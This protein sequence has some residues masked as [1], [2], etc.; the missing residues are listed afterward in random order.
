MHNDNRYSDPCGLAKML[1]SLGTLPRAL[2]ITSRIR[3]LRHALLNIHES[4]ARNTPASTASDPFAPDGL[5]ADPA[6]EDMDEQRLLQTV[7]ETLDEFDEWDAG[8]ASYWHSTFEQRT[9]PAPVGSVAA[10]GLHYDLETACTIILLRSSRLILLEAILEYHRRKCQLDPESE[11]TKAFAEYVPVLVRNVQATIDD[12]IYCVPYALG[13]L[14]AN[15]Q[16]WRIEYDGAPALI[17][18]NSLRLVPLCPHS[19]PDQVAV[20]ESI[21]KR[22]NTN[23]GVR[24]AAPWPGVQTDVELSAPSPASFGSAYEVVEASVEPHGHEAA[25]GGTEDRFPGESSA[26]ARP[27]SYVSPSM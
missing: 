17:I 14:D 9:A 20:I 4:S 12:L 7:F 27:Y 1:E 3:G 26:L 16:P 22:I 6:L 19:T 18:L 8:A 11:T 2:F 5:S 21:L 23:M 15:G 13:D 25:G 24:I 10:G